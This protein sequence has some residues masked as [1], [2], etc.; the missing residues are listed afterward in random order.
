MARRGE[1]S[2]VR[3]NAG[4]EQQYRRKLERHVDR[5]HRSILYWLSAAYRANEPEMAGD[6][7]PAV[8]LRNAMRA[9]TRRWSKEF[10]KLAGD[11]GPAFVKSSGAHADRAFQAQLKKAGF[12]VRFKLTAPVNDVMQASVGENVTLIKSIATKHL[13]EVEGLVM[14][15]VQRGR[16]LGELTKQLEDRYEI[17][18]K[19]AAFIAR[20]QN[21]KATAAVTRARQVQLGVEEGIWLHS[22]GGKKPRPTHVKMNGKRYKIAEGMWDSAV[23]RYVFPGEEPNCRC[24]GRSIL[25]GFD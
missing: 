25:P 5:M 7:S 6:E 18:R 8:S 21:N 15:S 20:D 10:A 3:P 17:T 23:G 19:R 12:T 1:V 22:H 2:A 11:Y 13:N 14:R 24:V 16:D 4:L 9:L